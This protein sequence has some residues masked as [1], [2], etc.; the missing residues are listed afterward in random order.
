MGI[1][2]ALFYLSGAL[3]AAAVALL[4]PASRSARAGE[5]AIAGLAAAA[6]AAV[7]RWRR[8]LP[9]WA[10]QPMNVA[11]T[12]MVTLLVLLAPDRVAAS[13]FALLYLYVPLDSFFFFSVP[14]AAVYQGLGSGCVVAV[15]LLGRIPAVEALALV[16]V[17]SVVAVVV[18]WL[19]R[20]AALAETD[21]L[22]GLPNRVALR[23]IVRLAM[24]HSSRAALPL[25]VA[26]VDIDRFDELNAQL[27]FAAGDEVL[28][29]AGA[30][31]RDL[32]P[33]GAT[34]A[35]YS[36]DSFA[37]V[38]PG[39]DAV[40]SAAVVEK[41]HGA[42]G[43]SCS[44]GVSERA[45]GDTVSLLLQRARSALYDAKQ[46]GRNR[47][48]TRVSCAAATNELAAAIADGQLRVL[49]QPLVSLESG[50][51]IGAEAL[52]RWAHPERGVL[53]PDAFVPLA[54][55]SD[56]VHEI[57]RVMIDAAV[58]E[59][60]T[61]PAA[62]KVSVN[63]SGRELVRGDYALT[64]ESALA[65]SG[66]DPAR[67][68]IEVTES[69]IEADGIKT[70]ASLWRLRRLGVRIALDD[71]GTGYSSLSRFD[72]LPIDIVKIDR[73]FVDPIGPATVEAPLIAAV[74]ALAHATGRTVLAEGIET[75][76]QAAVLRAH[77]VSEGQGYLFGRPGP[78]RMFRAASGQVLHGPA[79][80]DDPGVSATGELPRPLRHT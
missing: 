73:A 56:L 21:P 11:G 8:Q 40:A 60:A 47:V 3:T 51:V 57:G 67:L 5:L 12:A 80:V 31:L 55:E 50:G 1:T 26:F 77:G 54:E 63:A 33:A 70:L 74:C 44:S 24:E 68:V 18:A 64:V 27:G 20:A 49:Y 10:Y 9:R 41:L 37:L 69:S 53:G 28:R 76:H 45:P 52:V 22:T 23:R 29:R 25:G 16:I 78:P 14:V 36:G 75:P 62:L 30:L 6:A 4:T 58:R 66:L 39:C 46:S 48:A 32:L 35:R 19:V 59:A 17:D 13:A 42:I 34:A 65:A 7:V 71:F 38:L 61:W 72:R 15:A 2:G 79:G 43:R